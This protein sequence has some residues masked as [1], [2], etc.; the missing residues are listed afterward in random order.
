MDTDMEHTV[1][2]SPNG[3]GHEQREVNVRTIVVS[4]A[5]L[6]FG[7]FLACVVVVGIFRYF[8]DTYQ[9]DVSAKQ[10]QPQVPPEPR[11]EVAPAVELQT[12][13]AHEDHVLSTY[14]LVDPKDGKARVPIDR[15]IDMLAAKGLPSHDYLADILA[16]RKPPASLPPAVAAASQGK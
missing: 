10:A 13:R 16:G 2:H 14:A 3:T 4:L 7:A 15:A 11:L 1:E 8:N 5:F 6:L 12:L 9:P